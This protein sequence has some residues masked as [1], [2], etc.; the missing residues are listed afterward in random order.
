MQGIG[1]EDRTVEVETAGELG[2]QVLRVGRAA[3]VAA[4]IH[5]S[6]AAEAVYDGIDRILH[7]GLEGF[8][9]FDGG[10]GVEMRP[11]PGVDYS[12]AVHV[13]KPSLQNSKS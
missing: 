8:V 1:R 3:A 5:A 11:Q 4:E 2:G 13:V 9:F 10:D 12:C 6:A 7:G